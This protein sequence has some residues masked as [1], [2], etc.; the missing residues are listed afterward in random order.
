MSF[1]PLEE[2]VLKAIGLKGYSRIKLLKED[3]TL[4]EYT[5]TELNE[6]L[7]ELEKNEILYRTIVRIGGSANYNF[8]TY[9]LT[10]KGKEETQRILNQL[11]VLSEKQILLNEHDDLEI[12]YI[13]K[14]CVPLLQKKR[15]ILAKGDVHY[16]LTFDG[17]TFPLFID[18]KR[19]GGK[20]PTKEE[21]IQIFD[22]LYAQSTTIFYLSTNHITSS[23]LI[24]DQVEAW[25]KLRILNQEEQKPF[26]FYTSR[27][28]RILEGN[29]DQ[30]DSLINLW[31]NG[32]ERF[33]KLPSI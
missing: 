13:F 3:E 28:G 8:N 4:R 22:Q 31:N 14:E 19:H 24:L 30:W 27:T 10:E 23:F 29:G 21:Y 1:T 32:I 26:Q 12:G 25:M 16:T 5:F 9:E 7:K 15:I 18:T 2:Q 6:T 11:P 20:R 33:G 17:K